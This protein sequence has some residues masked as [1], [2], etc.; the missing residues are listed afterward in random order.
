MAGVGSGVEQQRRRQESGNRFADDPWGSGGLFRWCAIVWC[1]VETLV[2]LGVFYG[3]AFVADA[4]IGAGAYASACDPLHEA[5]APQS[6]APSNGLSQRQC[7]DA[8]LARHALVFQ[9]ASTALT[10]LS[11]A[12]GWFGDRFGQRALKLLGAGFYLLGF[13]LLGLE[14]NLLSSDVIHS[15]QLRAFVECSSWASRASRCPALWCSFR[16]HSSCHSPKIPISCS[17]SSSVRFFSA[18]AYNL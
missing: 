5:A 6:D 16:T 18:G 7:L 4:F 1:Y 13:T 15:P 11:L 8:K 17:G 9:V 3:W 2:F 12:F 10:V 14:F